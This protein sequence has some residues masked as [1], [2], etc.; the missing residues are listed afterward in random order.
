[1]KLVWLEVVDLIRVDEVDAVIMGEMV[2][3][4]GGDGDRGDDLSGIYFLFLRLSH[5][6]R[7]CCSLSLSS[8]VTS[9]RA[10]SPVACEYILWV[11]LFG[12]LS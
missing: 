9:T 3:F 5:C 10:V 2:E 8:I 1:M 11:R 12:C 4:N 7:S 6:D